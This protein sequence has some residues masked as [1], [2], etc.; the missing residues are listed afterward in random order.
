MHKMSMKRL[1]F[2]EFGVI[3]KE[4]LLKQER[5]PTF[6]K[7]SI[8]NFIGIVKKIIKVVNFLVFSQ[9]LINILC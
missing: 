2:N 1:D 3:L 9:N 6:K 7:F 4:L 8:I 5:K